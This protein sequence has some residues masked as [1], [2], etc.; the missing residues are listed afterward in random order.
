MLQQETSTGLASAS[1]SLA[2]KNKRLMLLCF[3]FAGF[4]LL[5]AF[6]SAPLYDLFCRVTGFAGTPRLAGS[7]PATISERIIPVR[8]NTDVAAGLDWRFQAQN[9][10]QQ[11]R[12]GEPNLIVYRAENLSSEPVIGMAVYNVSPPQAA[13]YFSKV[14]CFCFNEQL[15]KPGEIVEM[16]VQYFI[17]P[18]ILDDPAMKD[19]QS[20]TLSYTFY[21]AASPDYERAYAEYERRQEALLNQLR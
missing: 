21:K 17:D 2:N 12:I 7:L 19:L 4:M 16:P 5:V 3:G 15:L 8:F 14:Q 20:I 10:I 18:A 9:G 11:P 1:S 13:P 6:A